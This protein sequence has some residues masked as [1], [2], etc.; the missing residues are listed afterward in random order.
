MPSEPNSQAIRTGAEHCDPS[1]KMPVSGGKNTKPRPKFS[2][3]NLDFEAGGVSWLKKHSGSTRSHAAYWGGPVRGQRH[4]SHGDQSAPDLDRSHGPAQEPEPVYGCF[5]SRS[6]RRRQFRDAKAIGFPL[7]MKLIPAPRPFEPDYL[8]YLPPLPFEIGGTESSA[9]VRSSLFEFFGENFIKRFITFS[10]DDSSIMFTGCLLLSY[11]HRMALTGQGKKTILLHLKGQ[12]IKHIHT[13]LESPEGVVGPRC[14]TAILA[15]GAPIVCL[16]S[17]DLP[18]SLNIR[19][20][21]DASSK[22]DY[23]CCRECSDTAQRAHGERIVHKKAMERLL[24]V[25]KVANQDSDSVA[26]LQYVANHMKMYAFMESIRNCL[27]TATTD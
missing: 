14:L 25:N 5:D 21:V 18:K 17:Q 8:R 26:L 12:V 19:D 7:A 20:Y 15:L 3:V 4:Q 27:L 2:F 22:G 23:L 11:A 16:A 24:L 13:N 1:S 6:P 10:H 9:A